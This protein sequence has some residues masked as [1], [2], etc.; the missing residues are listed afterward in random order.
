[1]HTAISFLSHDGVPLEAIS[2]LARHQDSTVTRKVCRHVLADD[3]CVSPGAPG[4]FAGAGARRTTMER[5]PTVTS[6]PA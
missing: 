1:M 6:L 5:G 3:R 2:D 4:H